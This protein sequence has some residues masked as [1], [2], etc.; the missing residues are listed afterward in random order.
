MKTIKIILA[1]ALCALSLTACGTGGSGTVSPSPKSDMTDD[2]KNAADDVGKAA[3]DITD[4]AGSAV[5]DAVDG[6]ENA[7]GD[8]TGN[9][10]NG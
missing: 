8:V 9:A 5:K 10:K 3:D 1:A 7:V 4:G 2:V 6:V